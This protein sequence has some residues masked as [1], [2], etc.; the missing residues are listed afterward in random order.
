[1]AIPEIYLR[2]GLVI[3]LGLCVLILFVAIRLGLV[4]IVKSNERTDDAKKK[5]D[6]VPSS[7][8]FARIAAI[9][10]AVRRRMQQ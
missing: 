6:S 10:A 4:K 2:F 1:M 5:S 9:A 3:I 8:D 7:I